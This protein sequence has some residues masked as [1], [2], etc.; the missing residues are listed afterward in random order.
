MGV[1]GGVLSEVASVASFS[2][3]V[4]FAIKFKVGLAVGDTLCARS[5]P[6]PHQVSKV[7]SL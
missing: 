1:V 3:L 5:Y 6:Y 7:S 4:G 2:S